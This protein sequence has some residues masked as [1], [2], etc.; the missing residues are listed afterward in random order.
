M[1][2][3]ELNELHVSIVQTLELMVEQNKIEKKI[4]F[5]FCKIPLHIDCFNAYYRINN[6]HLFENSV[7]TPLVSSTGSSKKRNRRSR[8]LYWFIINDYLWLFLFIIQLIFRP[9]RRGYETMTYIIKVWHNTS[10]FNFN[11]I[12]IIVISKDAESIVI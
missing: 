7:Q 5:K 10:N 2:V 8:L 12:I 3:R 4:N 11:R 9:R 6:I 1:I